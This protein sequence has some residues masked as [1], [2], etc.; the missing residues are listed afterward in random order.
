MERLGYDNTSVLFLIS[1]VGTSKE[2]QQFVQD[3]GNDPSIGSTVYVSP[4]DLAAKRDVF[5]RSGD[6]NAYTLLVSIIAAFQLLL[7][8]CEF[9]LT[10]ISS[11][12]DPAI[13]ISFTGSN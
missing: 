9:T 1:R 5:K 4:S 7:I 10:I 8:V 11:L 3:I 13:P 12:A 6:S 2:A